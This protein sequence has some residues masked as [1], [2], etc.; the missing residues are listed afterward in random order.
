MMSPNLVAR[1]QVLGMESFITPHT[2]HPVHKIAPTRH[3]DPISG[4][5]QI[6]PFDAAHTICVL[7]ETNPGE[8]LE[9]RIVCSISPSGVSGC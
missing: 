5:S 6:N 1:S 3:T 2:L 8:W 4:S 9:S 7:I